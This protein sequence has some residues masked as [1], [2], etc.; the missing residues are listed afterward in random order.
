MGLQM[1]HGD[2]NIS[3]IF[4]T[5]DGSVKLIDYDRSD[6]LLDENGDDR[7]SSI[8]PEHYT[9]A[10]WDVFNFHQVM[11]PLCADM[12]LFPKHLHQPL[13]DFQETTKHS[14]DLKEIHNKWQS[15]KRDHC[16]RDQRKINT[17]AARHA[18]RTTAKWERELT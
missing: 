12:K 2:A 1:G 4:V 10:E 8:A 9:V 17:H 5:K 15:F 6:T 13:L 3:N 16:V 11:M 18:K 7:R 14:R